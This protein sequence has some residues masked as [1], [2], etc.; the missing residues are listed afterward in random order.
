MEAENSPSVEEKSLIIT[1]NSLQGGSEMMRTPAF[2]WKAWQQ[3][4][5]ELLHTIIV[6]F[7]H[8]MP[9]CNI[10]YSTFWT[11]FNSLFVQKGNGLDIAPLS[12]ATAEI[13]SCSLLL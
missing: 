4:I 11:I 8:L 3:I 10:S 6:G 1:H 12:V 13:S 9:A 7:A 2:T 5:F